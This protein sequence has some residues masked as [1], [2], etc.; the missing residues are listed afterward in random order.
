M[1]DHIERQNIEECVSVWKQTKGR[2]L[3]SDKIINQQSCGCYMARHT[4]EHPEV[5]VWLDSMGVTC[6]R[7]E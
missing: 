1:T 3:V 4:P 5:C 6:L 2:C 7:A